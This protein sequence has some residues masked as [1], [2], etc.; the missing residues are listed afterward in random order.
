MA[1]IDGYQILA[2]DMNTLLD[3][4][5]S[6]IQAEA[7]SKTLGAYFCHTMYNV[8]NTTPEYRRQWIFVAPCNVYIETLAVQ[9]MDMVGLTTVTVNVDATPTTPYS[10]S[11]TAVTGIDKFDRLLFDNSVSNNRRFALDSRMFRLLPKGSTITVTVSTSNTTTPSA[12]QIIL[13]YRQWA[14]RT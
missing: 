13:P 3:G 8:V 7:N 2:S 9:T 14:Q 5:L 6:S 12:I 10:V 11:D 4:Y 1:I